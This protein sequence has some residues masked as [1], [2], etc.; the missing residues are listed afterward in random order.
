[1][2]WETED[3]FAKRITVIRDCFPT[4]D[5]WTSEKW[6]KYSKTVYALE[7]KRWSGESEVDYIKRIFAKDSLFDTSD[8][9]WCKRIFLIQEATLSSCN[10][11]YNDAYLS[12]YFSTYYK[13]LDKVR[14]TEAADAWL[15]RALTPLPGESFD[16]ALTRIKFI[17]SVTSDCGFWKVDYFKKI[18]TAKLLQSEYLVKIQKAFFPCGCGGAAV[19]VSTSTSSAAAASS[20]SSSQVASSTTVVAA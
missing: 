15:L 19:A 16:N 20:S 18:Q 12:S 8:E 17:K 10:I 9:I 1:E 2:A 14:A 3:I 13:T 4:L 6:F 5:L 11:W 7:F